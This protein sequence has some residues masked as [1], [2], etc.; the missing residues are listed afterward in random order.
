MPCSVCSDLGV[1]L[2]PVQPAVRCLGRGH[3]GS[4]V[5]VAVTV[6]PGGAAAQVS[7]CDIQTCCSA[8]SPS[9]RT[10]ASAAARRSVAPYSPVPGMDDRRRR[11]T[12][13]ELE[14]VADAQDRDSSTEQASRGRRGAR[15]VDRGGAAG[16]DDRGR[17]AAPASPRRSWNAGTTSRV[18]LAF[19][20]PPRDQLGVLGAEVDDQDGAG[21][22][23]GGLEAGGLEGGT[24]RAGDT[25]LSSICHADEFSWRWRLRPAPRIPPALPG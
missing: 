10:P 11:V 1:E 24:V 18:D 14:S 6:N 2:H 25:A 12:D 20:D 13:H 15:R 21:F 9:S 23:A 16:Q 17:A 4:R 7:P 8:G 3:R 19:A 22:E 5:V